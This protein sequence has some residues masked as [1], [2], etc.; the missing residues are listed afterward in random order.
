MKNTKLHLFLYLAFFGLTLTY[1]VS[2]YHYY[3][4]LSLA[5]TG[6]LDGVVHGKV[7]WDYGDGFNEFDSIN[8]R[9][10]AEIKDPINVTLGTVTIEPSGIKHESSDGYAVEV[11]VDETDYEKGAFIVK[12]SHEWGEWINYQWR[13]RG[14]RLRLFP[15]SRLILPAQESIFKVYLMNSLSTGVAKV[16]SSSGGESY[17]ET[18]GN[19]PNEQVETYYFGQREKGPIKAIVDRYRLEFQEYLPLPQQRLKG[20]RFV[21]EEWRS[22]KAIRPAKQLTIRLKPVFT[23]NGD[24][25]WP[26]EKLKVNGKAIRWNDWRLSTTTAHGAPPSLRSPGKVITFEGEIRS[27]EAHFSHS[28]PMEAVEILLDGTDVT[29]T[30]SQKTGNGVDVISGNAPLTYSDVSVESTL[31]RDAAGEQHLFPATSR[32][33]AEVLFSKARLPNLVQ[34]EKHP[35][36]LLAQV[37]TAAFVTFI[38]YWIG[39]LR[40]FRGLRSIRGGTHTVFIQQNRWVFWCVLGVGMMLNMI[41]LLVEWPG[42]LTPDSI[43]VHGEAKRLSFGNHNPYIYSLFVLGLYNVVDSHLS[44]IIF[45]MA[46]FHILSGLLFYYLYRE[47]APVGILFVCFCLITMSVPVTLLNITFWK[48]VLYTNLVQRRQYLSIWRTGRRP[49]FGT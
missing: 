29:A 25:W 17:Y 45:Q 36:L 11:I 14:V 12:G 44:V 13:K 43:I 15:G 16:S 40:V 37:L 10:S 18:Y 38:F 21:P 42:S 2:T 32:H 8:V 27:Y 5:L 39:K 6:T 4:G 23:Y 7:Y 30:A 19:N 46:G 20:I 31:I 28:H 1:F 24:P 33:S 9:L 3:P 48:D 41:I 49:P 35:R 22:I 47:G 26:L 34:T